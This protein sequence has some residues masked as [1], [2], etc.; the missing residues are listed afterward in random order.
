MKAMCSAN[1]Q[2]SVLLYRVSVLVTFTVKMMASVGAEGSSVTHAAQDA[3]QK[4]SQS[5]GHEEGS[6]A[7]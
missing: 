4:K 6:S 5:I 3:E 7:C 2:E 1:E